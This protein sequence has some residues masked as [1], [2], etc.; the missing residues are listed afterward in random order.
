MTDRVFADRAFDR[1]NLVARN[2]QL[3]EAFHQA[4]VEHRVRDRLLQAV[5][6]FPFT[7][8]NFG[9]NR[10][11][12]I[13]P[14]HLGDMLLATPA[15]RALR[16]A[17]PYIEI[18]VLAGSWSAD[19]LANIPEVDQVLTINFPGFNRSQ[20]R[21]NLLSPYAQLVRVSRQL[22]RIGYGSA[23]IMR[24]DH[25]WG[26]MLAH[27]AGINERI[28]YNLPN[29]GQFLTMQIDHHHEHVIHQSM[30]LIEHWTGHIPDEEIVYRYDIYE[31]DQAYV[32]GYLEESGI[33]PE[34][35][36]ICIHPGAG[37]WVK[38][39]QEEKWAQVA[40]TLIDQL[41]AEVVF[42]GSEQEGTI[43]EQ[44][45][46]HME[47]RSYTTVGDMRIDQLA[48]LYARA[49][50]VIG[51][52][53]GPMHLASAVGTP[54]VTLFGPADP[55]EFAPWGDRNKHFVITTPIGCRPCRVLDW[56][57]DDAL[58]HPCVTEITIGQVLDAARRAAQAD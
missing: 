7:P 45:R 8:L 27:L 35:P 34:Q 10:V 5:A 50:V 16:A 48:A 26:A 6:M 4:P 41:D 20:T 49:R 55:V 23:V 53:S 56:G 46:A 24:P 38:R 21:R 31:E 58:N 37:T 29:I 43:V 13:K 18:H 17:K 42:T 54:T 14:D 9:W 15:L 32:D 25:W 51:P 44:I 2:R 57:D 22:R 47:H 28:G 3:A 19:I 12:F 11:L 40:D 30:R 1:E 39:W 36:I 33:A 52:D